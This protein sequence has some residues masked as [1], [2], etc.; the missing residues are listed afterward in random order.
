[1][2]LIWQEILTHIV[3]FIILLLVLKRLAWKPL[4]ALL[5]QRR[6]TIQ[7]G[8][9]QVAQAQQELERLK[10]EYGRRIAAIEE[11]ARRRLQAATTEGKQLA[12]DIQEQARAQ[13]QQILTKT[14]D[15]MVLEIAQAKV[16]LR[17]HVVALTLEACGKLLRERLDDAK[18]RTLILRF[19]QELEHVEAKR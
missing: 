11:E 9:D 14:R 15:S 18:D 1:M 2:E 6:Q 5:D 19:M 4:L 12:L 3:G 8:L 10:T 17:D 16:E 7:Q 13:A